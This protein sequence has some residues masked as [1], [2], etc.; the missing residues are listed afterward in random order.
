MDVHGRLTLDISDRNP[1]DDFELIQRLGSGSYGEVFK[2]RNKATGELAAV[3]IVTKEPDED[4]SVIQQEV[5]IVKTCAQKNIVA[6][7]GSY[8]QVNKL[9]ICME[10][11]GGGSLQDIYQV[12]GALS[13]LQTAYVCRETL[14]GLSYLHNQGKIHRDIKGA[15]ILLNDSGDVKVADFGISA[16]LTATF[17]RRKSFIGTPY[18]MAPEVAAVELKGGYTELCDVW[19]LGITAIELAEL[20]PPMFHIHPLRVLFL[21]SKSGFQPPKLKEKS[22]WTAPFHNFVKVALTKSPKKRPSAS[23]LLTHQFVAQPGLHASLTQELLEKLRN[24]EKH[25]DISIPDEEEEVE[26]LPTFSRILS[27]NRHPKATRSSSDIQLHQINLKQIAI[28]SEADTALISDKY[29]GTDCGLRGTPIS[30]VS[31]RRVCDSSSDDDDYDDVDIP[32][33]IDHNNDTSPTEDSPPPLP[34]KP[35]FRTCSADAKRGQQRLHA[36]TNLV[37]CCS[38]PNIPRNPAHAWSEGIRNPLLAAS[39]EPSLSSCDSPSSVPPTLPPK[40]GKK[41]AGVIFKKIFNGCPLKIHS[42]TCWSHPTTKDMHVILGAEEGIF[43]LNLTESQASLE[44]LYPTRT[45]WV[46]SINNVLMT[47]TGKACHLYSHGLL[48]LHEQSRREHRLVQMP[49]HRLLRRK[50]T[51]SKVPDTKGCKSCCVAHNTVRDSWFLCAALEASILLLEWYE[52]LQKFMLLKHFDFPLPN[53][54]RVFQMLVVPGEQYPLVCI[55]VSK[56]S[57][58]CTSVRFQTIN[59]NS[60]TSWFTDCVAESSYSGPIQVIQT[61]SDSVLVLTDTLGKLEPGS[62]SEQNPLR[63]YTLNL[64][65]LQGEPLQTSLLTDISFKCSVVSVAVFRDTVL[66]FMEKGFQV[67]NIQSAE[68]IADCRDRSLQVLSSDRMVIV[69]A[70]QSSHGNTKNLYIQE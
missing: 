66:V 13:E 28:S 11:C 19:S 69:E 65:N 63:Q 30:P 27:K 45:T 36:P 58:S 5:L 46:Y 51:S 43:T 12:T 42:A 52:P 8:M 20:Q 61:G 35:R 37:R 29:S 68:V 24:P 57:P 39:S 15:N 40:K 23:K 9:W 55:G 22:K 62:W 21:M 31:R 34:P 59:L 7:Y 67:L 2:A 4:F 48:A 33:N 70:P 47:I 64:V 17:A 26:A 10:Y 54:L 41:Q 16:Q 14:Q 38:G 3:K 44:L 49:A 50:L 32:Q 56:R 53:L 1:Q 25:K 18:W 60:L 6:Y